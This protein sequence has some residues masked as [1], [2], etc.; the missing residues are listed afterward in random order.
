MQVGDLVLDK[1]IDEMG[2]VIEKAPFAGACWVVRLSDDTHV[3][4]CERDLDLIA[5]WS[6]L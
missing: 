1:V 6:L 5:S 4:T 2:I 3:I